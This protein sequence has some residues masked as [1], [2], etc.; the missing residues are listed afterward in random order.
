MR[1]SVDERL[2]EFK[3]LWAAVLILGLRVDY[4]ALMR[5]RALMP[6]IDRNDNGEFTVEFMWGRPPFPR[7]SAFTAE[8]CHFCADFVIDFGLNLQQVS[9]EV[10]AT[11]D[12]L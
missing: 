1:E 9:A 8:A 6:Y 10:S 3:D 5:F 2:L 7:E 4:Q 11:V 12:I